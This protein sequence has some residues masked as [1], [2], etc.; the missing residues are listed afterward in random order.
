MPRS[1]VGLF[2][3]LS[4]VTVAAYGALST[5][6]QIV[7]EATGP[8]GAMVVFSSLVTVIGG[9]DGTNGRPA[10]TVACSPASGSVF[11]IGTTKVSCVGSEGSTGSF[12]IAVVDR[13]APRMTLPF[14]FTIVT[15]GA[16]PVTYNASATDIVDGTVGVS[17]SPASGSTFPLGMTAVICTAS[18]S[19]G[20]TAKG[21][22]TVTLVTSTPPPGSAKIIAEAT[23]PDGAHVTFN[24]GDSEDDLGRLGSGGCSPAPGSIFPLGDTTV[25][26][27]SGSFILRVVDT[28]PPTLSLPSGVKD[29]AV[30]A[31]GAPV[32]F[33]ATATDLVDGNVNV[34][35]APPS[36]STFPI[37]TTRVTC[38][39]SDSRSNTA[40]GSFDVEIATAPVPPQNPH[41][42]T[43]EATG[44]GGAVVTFNLG[45]DLG[46]RPIT[47]SPASGS[48][49]PIAA[50]QVLCSSGETFTVTV[51]DTTAPVLTL[52]SLVSAE[53]NALFGATV[54]FT[55]TATDIVDGSVGVTCAPP[56]GSLFPIGT[57]LV[58]CSAT[59]AHGNKGT[60]SFSVKVTDT[61]PPT[62]NS[63]T[64]SPAT[65][66]PP[67]G[68]LID[69]IV[70]VQ[71]VDIA[72][73]SPI[74]KIV[75]ITC[76][77]P[78]AP[79]DA[80]IVGALKARLRAERSSE[81]TGRVYTLLIEAKDASGNTSHTSVTVTVPHD[82]GDKRRAAG[83]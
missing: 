41:D 7:A 6:G 1:H 20:N 58:S 45:N 76:N 53:A 57:T 54:T 52:P 15:T 59:D 9:N 83:H 19:H 51:V 25:V 18:D 30:D 61:T 23:G 80:Q 56:S 16:E 36:G 27:P 13:T 44:P 46:G 71:V 69:V 14:D 47:C 66:W 26:C 38:S 3:V 10:D 11:P 70:T 78:I 34:T 17:C 49:F 4:L 60:G 67:N 55:A 63:A 62:I 28:T 33:S 68:N 5:P 72:D 74:V 40:T 48:T 77:E 81:G 35:C 42:I 37:G 31:S 64:V 79:G 2:I 73:P 82:Q 22:F 75:S 21:G 43:A 39:A 32:A 50:T 8:D 24:T 29:V 65:L 12:D